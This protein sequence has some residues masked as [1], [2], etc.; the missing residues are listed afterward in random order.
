MYDIDLSVTW[1]KKSHY[2]VYRL[3]ISN[4]FQADLG[5]EVSHGVKERPKETPEARAY[6]C[7][8]VYHH[9]L[10]ILKLITP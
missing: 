9:K 7:G 2:F 4:G 3:S 8:D 1:P 10:I 6:H 5:A